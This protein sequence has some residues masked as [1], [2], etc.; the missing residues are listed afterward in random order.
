MCNPTTDTEAKLLWRRLFADVP[1]FVV[2]RQEVEAERIFGTA[3]SA[4]NTSS[5]AYE[6]A[7]QALRKPGDTAEEINELRRE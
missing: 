3:E 4:R 6:L 2:F 5:T 1:R 7:R